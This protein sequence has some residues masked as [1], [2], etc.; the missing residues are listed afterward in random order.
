MKKIQT[1]FLAFSFKTILLLSSIVI[2]LLTFFNLKERGYIHMNNAEH[3]VFFQNGWEFYTALLTLLFVLLLIT[4]GIER[5]S[6]V[7]LFSILAGVYLGLGTYLILN[8]DSL[9][10]AD[11]HYLFKAA[12]EMN[13]GDFSSFDKIDATKYMSTFPTQMGL[14]SLFRV[15]A[16]FTTNPKY[17]FYLQLLMVNCSHFLLWRIANLLFQNKTINNLTILL[18]YLFLPSLFLILWLYGDIPGLLCLLLAFYAYIKYRKKENLLFAMMSILFMIAACIFRSNYLI[19]FVLLLILQFLSIIQKF[20]LRKVIFPVLLIFL[21][22]FV[23]RKIQHYYEEKIQENIT[24]PPQTA[25]VVMGLND[26]AA[27]PGYFDA[28]TTLIRVWNN[29]DDEKVEQ[30]VA[31][32]LKDRVRI[33]STDREYAINF[34]SKKLSAIWNE[35]TFQSIYAG[36]LHTREQFVHTDTLKNLYMEGSY[37][38]I[39]NK[40]M[41]VFLGMIYLLTLIYALIQFLQPLEKRNFL[42]LVPLLYL[43]GGFLFHVLWEAKARYVYPY[44][45]MLIPVVAFSFSFQVEKIS[46]KLGGN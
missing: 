38:H 32:D 35:P 25:W 3:V 26:K 42:Y 20:K 8:V 44:I 2:L 21:Y 13:A 28:Y 15:Y 7:A 23:N 16:S 5:I 10:R 12:L 18:S 29:Y 24:F 22:L 33:L 31:K 9:M 41:S 19:F 34:F 6:S 4:K 46:K 17:L 14:L 36:P 27:T 39:Y 43:L 30:V 11:P 40:Y 37:Y 1:I 45:Y